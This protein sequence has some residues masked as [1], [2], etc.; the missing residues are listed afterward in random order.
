MGQNLHFFIRINNDFVP[1]VSYSRNQ[2]VYSIFSGVPYERVR[3][4]ETCDIN[5]AIEKADDKL[6]FYKKEID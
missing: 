6:V 1:M 2:M 5:H 3:A 4:L